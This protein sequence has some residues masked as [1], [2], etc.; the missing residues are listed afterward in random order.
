MREEPNLWGRMMARLNG[1]VPADVLEAYR[2]AGV[3][4]Y[5]LL[6]DLEGRRLDIVLGS[7]D[8]WAVAPATQAAL[9]CGWNAFALQLL[10]DQLLAADYEADPRSVG[11][12]PPATAQQALSFYGQVAGWLE[13]ARRAESN[14]SFVLDVAIPA[15]LPSWTEVEPCPPQHLT[16]VRAAT[17]QLRRHAVAGVV[18]FHLDLSDPCRKK[19]HEQIHELLAEIEAAI[20]YADRLWAPDVPPA[21]HEDIERRSR[22][23]IQRL[24]LLG[25][26]IAM[27]RLALRPIPTPVALPA[28]AAGAMP[29]QTG[30]DP[31]CLSDS[32]G[33]AWWQR[34]PQAQ[35]AVHAL[36][37]YDPD[38]ARTLA[39]Q[40]EIDLA[41]DRGDVT[42]ATWRGY[43]LG[44][45]SSCPWA[46]IYEVLHPATIAGRMLQPLQHFTFDVSAEGVAHGR[47]FRREI[48]VGPFHPAGR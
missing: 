35:G 46:P 24:Y 48:L 11:F 6:D 27:P 19:A 7:G 15:P 20:D 10:G 45:F 14:P 23:A 37:A 5:E 17:A 3:E 38:P 47:P 13:R 9:V 2:R 22:L 8:A 44:H 31:W 28:P 1:E 29:G 34:D 43:R 32:A 16:A 42:I 18:G 25:Q 21:I 36:W 40:V 4:V 26:L 39:I 30:F 12:V 41:I 33:R